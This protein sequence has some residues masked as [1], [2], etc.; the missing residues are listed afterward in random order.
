MPKKTDKIGIIILAAGASR[1]M[2]GKQKQLLEIEGK[3]LLRK[4]YE[5]A[6]NSV[7]RPIIVVLG[8]NA[9]IIKSGIKDIKAQI[10]VNQNWEKGLSSSIKVGVETLTKQNPDLSAICIMLCDQPLITAKII[11]DLAATYEKTDKLIVACKYAETNGVPAIFSN[12][13]F[14]ELCEIKG[15]KGAREIIENHS[16]MLETIDVPEA[17]LDVDTPEDFQKLNKL[18]GK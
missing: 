15:D 7:C 4:A 1:R 16:E 12:E 9:E 13:L 8:A 10:I 17:A 5:S 14:G 6:V 11:N 3:T 18:N 2:N